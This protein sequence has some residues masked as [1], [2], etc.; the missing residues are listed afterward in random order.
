MIA[1]HSI[2]AQIDGLD[3]TVEPIDATVTLDENWSPFV[4]VRLQCPVVDT[5]QLAALDP[6]ATRRGFITVRQEFGRLPILHDLSV[7]YRPGPLA[8]LSAAFGTVGQVSTR[9]YSHWSTPGAPY[10]EPKLRTFNLALRSR[11]INHEAGTV[12]LEL[13]SDEALLQDN[14]HVATAPHHVDATNLQAAVAY[15]LSRIGAVLYQAVAWAQLVPFDS[16]ANPWEPGESAWDWLAPILQKDNL[17]LWCD[18]QR[19]WWLSDVQTERTTPPLV[20]TAA[21]EI[22]RADDRISR[23]EGFYTAV[24]VTY[25]HDGQKWYDLARLPESITGINQRIR[26]V[27]YDRPYPG[28]GAA[29]RLLR[30]L[31][32][33]ARSIT[34]RAVSDY[35]AEP[36][37]TVQIEL[38]S[39][40]EQTG[41]VSAVTWS[42]PDDEMDV[43]FRGLVDAGVIETEYTPV[44][45][46][47]E[48]S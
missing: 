26:R 25:T 43:T 33:R 17:R 41:T 20:L 40:P 12:T 30:S 44:P 19:R 4:Q 3:A 11:S 15:I 48:E 32:G 36:G 31:L 2:S 7:L 14:A 35:L 24:I 9:L 6:R 1:S 10:Q 28:P 37:R 27:T 22:T 8:A 42:Y 5:A 46:P 21:G 16:A 38:P 39:T 29:Q 13:A 23:D 47:E 34:V 45:D 18:P